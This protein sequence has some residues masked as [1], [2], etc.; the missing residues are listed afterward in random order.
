MDSRKRAEGCAVGARGRRPAVR[1]RARRRGVGR[2]SARTEA[3]LTD[4]SG[5]RILGGAAPPVR[6]RRPRRLARDGEKGVQG[7]PRGPGGPPHRSL[8]IK[9]IHTL[10]LMEAE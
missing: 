5:N 1:Y 9:N 8:L 10:D 6:S 3:D 4:I 7:V 2:D